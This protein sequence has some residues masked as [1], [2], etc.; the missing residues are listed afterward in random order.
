M[1][2]EPAHLAI[3]A[4]GWDSVDWWRASALP[5]ATPIVCLME[6]DEAL[7]LLGCWSHPASLLPCQL[8][9]DTRVGW[10]SN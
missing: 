3:S 10:M 7:N 6:D 5:S 8:L 2:I 1:L 9:L 4:V